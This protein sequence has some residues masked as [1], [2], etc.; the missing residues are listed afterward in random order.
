MQP[1]SEGVQRVIRARAQLLES[2]PFFG[3]Q[4]L[5]LKV[6]EDSSCAGM[7]TDAQTLGFNPAYVAQLLDLEIR[8][9]IAVTVMKITAGHPWR[10]GSRDGKRWNDAC[11]EAIHPL[12]VDAGFRLPAGMVA[13]TE[14]PGASA[15]YI[16]QKLPESVQDTPPPD[17]PKPPS[18]EGGNAEP[19]S[20]GTD[21]G[22]GNSSEGSNQEPEPQGSALSEVR[23]APA[24]LTSLESECK[25]A[26]MTGLSMQG[27]LSA[28]IE[29]IVD[30]M[31]KS[32][33]NWRAEMQN[34]VEVSASVA[35]DYSMS[36][37]NKHF[38]YTG[39]ILPGLKGSRMRSMVIVRDTSGS[40]G[41]SYKALF[42]GELLDLIEEMKPEEVIVL[43]IDSQIC[44]VQRL[45]GDGMGD[46]FDGN[47]SG[48]GGT[49]F[50]PAFDYVEKEEIDCACLVYLTD[51]DG[52]F[53]A[54][55]PDYPVLWAV[56]EGCLRMK[57]PPFGE[58]IELTLN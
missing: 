50:I 7:W 40:I 47:M 24:G 57:T 54:I 33:V 46:D 32:K 11:A 39:L 8:G 9:L 51:L 6:V 38:L 13:T 4:A 2:E 55:E 17:V 27:E 53:P 19:E 15:E 49:S 16:Y 1:N 10:Q 34:F 21:P 30:E 45:A 35:P 29:S 28:G 43:D 12:I 23:P 36:V 44:K 18:S 52:K 48:G 26:A 42:N 3:F 56:P 58:V 25:A 14:F 20:G 31:Q 5:R 37:V 22:S 41:K